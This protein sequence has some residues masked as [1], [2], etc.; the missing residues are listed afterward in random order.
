MT[1]RFDYFVIFAEMRTGSNFLE[2]N[3]DEFDTLKCY[4]EAFNPYFMVAPDVPEMLGVT[5]K[6]RDAD[7]MLLLRRMVEKTDGTPGFRFFSD[8]DPRVFEEI[9]DNP[10]CGKVILTRNHLESYVSRKI[11]WA[12]GQWQLN[13]V[14]D[15]KKQK[16]RFDAEEFETLFHGFKEFQFKIKERLQK[17]GQSAF[18]IDYED[19][20]DID[21]VNGLATFLGDDGSISQFAG[22][23][24]KQNPELL[25]DKVTNLDALE[26]TIQRIDPFGLNRIPNFEPSRP[27][28]VTTYVTSE[29]TNLVFLPVKGGP[30]TQVM[31]WLEG[32]GPLARDFT[33]KTLRQW[34][35][36]HKGHRSFTVLRHP[37]ARLHSVFCENFV[38][39]GPNTFTE[40]R[41]SLRD[42]YEVPFLA[43]DSNET[44]TSQR[45]TEAFLR[46]IA[47]VEKNLSG[48]TG[49]RVDASWATQS[50]V[51]QGFASFSLPDHVL[52]ETELEEG[53]GGLLAE[54][55]LATTVT[56][57]NMAPETPYSLSEIYNEEIEKA[58]RKIYQ[59]DYMMFGFR[60]WNKS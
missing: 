56:M 21:V 32:F 40:I 11:A 34:K 3:L 39:D 25:E 9:I 44:W 1:K 57:P 46:F 18:Y 59:R 4:G 24:K 13:D 48:Q 54:Q 2:S 50:A 49:I 15:V 42:S 37:V 26:K 12:T 51:L 35:R 52:R 29:D 60:P 36:A 7:P 19:A 22:T 58:V 10:R 23:F 28:A 17:S 38:C 47:F 31:S 16:V 53:L 43:E 20:Q 30:Q 33:Q 14:K 6:Q 8:H 27:A 5:V 41:R 45:H 55:G